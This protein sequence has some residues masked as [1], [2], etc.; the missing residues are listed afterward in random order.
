MTGQPSHC[1]FGCT[2]DH[3]LARDAAAVVE[4]A[5]A[6]CAERGLKFTPA[7]EQVLECLAESA[8]PLG[9]Y[10]LIEGLAA[11]GHARPAPPIVYRAL[12][13]LTA[14]GFV[15]RIESRNA[16]L[17]CDH[18]HHGA[19]D[20]I[21]FLLCEQCGKA[22]EASGDTLGAGLAALARQAGFTPR[23]QVIE[24]AGLCPDCNLNKNH[25]RSAL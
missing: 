9:A 15:H 25:A 4:R 11:K 8:T 3:A 24:I 22:Q 2:H 17:A 23:A 7:R 12:E 13:F 20:V 6:L 16:F 19:Q 1:S 10:D 21:V 5:R 18:T 14:N